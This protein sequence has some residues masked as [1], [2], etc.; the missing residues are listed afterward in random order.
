VYPGQEPDAPATL[1]LKKERLPDRLRS[2][3]HPYTSP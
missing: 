3:A 2:V 1:F